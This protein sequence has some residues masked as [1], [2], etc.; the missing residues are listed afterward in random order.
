ME[1]L[2]RLL[3]KER[4]ASIRDV[5]KNPSKT[6]RGITRV[7]R[8]GKT[9]GFFFSH[10][11]FDDLLEDIEAMASKDLRARVRFARKGFKKHDAV[12]PSD[13]LKKYGV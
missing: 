5:Q 3:V 11:E 9:F 4:I 13:L 12:S 6:L 2:Y 7:M 8:G 10:E 1:K